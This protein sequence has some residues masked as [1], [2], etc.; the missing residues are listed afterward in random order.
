MTATA[1]R[2]W[3]EVQLGDVAQVRWG[4][5]TTTKASY[6]KEGYRAFSASGHDGFLDHF[7]HEGPGI[8]LSA[9]GAQ[10]GKTWFT[11]GR[12]SC[13]KNTIYIKGSERA[14]T[15]FLFYAT[16]SPDF[17]PKR[18]AAQPFISQGDARKAKLHLPP[19]GDQ[20]RIAAILGAYDGLIDVNRRRIALLEEM[21]RSLFE[22]WFVRFR[23]PG[24]ENI[25]INET[26]DGPLPEGWHRCYLGDVV[27][28]AYG[29]AL[30]ADERREG[31]V[32]VYGSSGVV[33]W[34]D[35]SLVEGPGIIVGRKGNVGSVIWSD[36]D[37]WPIDTTFFVKSDVPLTFLYEA[38]KRLP[39]QNND[40]AV[41]GLNK[42][43]ALKLRLIMPSEAV[44]HQYDAFAGP[45]R[46]QLRLLREI[47]ERL[48]NSRDLLLPRLMSGRLTLPAA[49][50][51]LERAAAAP[52]L[53]PAE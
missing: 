37:F 26:P 53:V 14:D 21:A 5:T 50:R 29:K 17:W 24:H 47:S 36:D 7:D 46:M 1:E 45:I 51:E 49:E 4:D 44:I 31:R 30:K 11:E 6:V 32:L 41:P 38:L 3:S 16:Q 43:A 13:I 34:H 52:E 18:G 10:C 19:I 48:T 35:E 28:F 22:E 15:R 42:S 20:S 39:F 12:W 25:T 27:E 23:F 40:A 8:V 33:G 9:I 2:E